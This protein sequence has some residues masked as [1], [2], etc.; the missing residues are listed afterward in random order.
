MR[1]KII[2]ISTLLLEIFLIDLE[3]FS[4]GLRSNRGVSNDKDGDR[5]ENYSS[6]S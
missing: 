1:N 2:V 4:T 3:I 6:Y 5:M